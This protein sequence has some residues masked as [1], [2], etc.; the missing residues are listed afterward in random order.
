MFQQCKPGVKWDDMHRL[1][2]NVVVTHLQKIGIIK[3]EY[4]L[5][6]LEQKRIGAIFM[7]HGL[8]HLIGLAIHDVGGYTPCC[9]PRRAEQGFN[10]LRTRRELSENM[11]LTIEPGCYFIEHILGEAKQNET[12]SMCIDWEKVEE[13][14]SV[15][16]VRI[17]DDVYIT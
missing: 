14:K 12:Q 13:Y 17:E 11:C 5:D 8:G 15:G 3:P 1:A 7:P 6:T 10:K 9:P 4:S 16:G 2:E